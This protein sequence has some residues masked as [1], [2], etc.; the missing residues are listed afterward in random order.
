MA[1]NLTSFQET[2]TIHEEAGAAPRRDEATEVGPRLDPLREV[3]MSIPVQ[4]NQC[5]RR[6]ALKEGYAGKAVKCKG[7]GRVLRVPERPARRP[8][9]AAITPPELDVFGVDDPPAA[10]AS[11]EDEAVPAPRRAPQGTW[12][13]EGRGRAG[14]RGRSSSA[15]SF[16]GVA[17]GVLVVALFA[18]RVY[19]RVIR[20]LQDLPNVAATADEPPGLPPARAPRRAGPIT[21]PAFPELGP[22]VV[23]EPGVR[24]H[25]VRL[26]PNDPTPESPGH[27]GK[28]WLYLPDG[29]HDP[30]ALPCILI[31]G[32]G[33]N[34]ITGMDLGA[35]DRREHLPYVRAGFAV[36]AYELDGARQESDGG[37]ALLRSC[38]AFL[39]AQAGLVNARNALGFLE[40]RV[41]EVD[42]RRVYAVGHSSA[43]TLALLVAENEPRIRGCVAFAPVLDTA[44][45]F[46]EPA[47]AELVRLLPDAVDFFD[48]YNPRQHEGAIA[49]PVFL[50]HAEDDSNVPVSESL[51][52]RDRLASLGKSVTLET[53]P[54][55]DHYEAMVKQGIPLAIAWLKRLA[56]F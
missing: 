6:Y 13:S 8:A 23:L 55:G 22:G 5:G 3:P 4:C 51:G 39:A 41:P 24:F 36:L 27:R 2:A 46:P 30:R 37:E 47:R 40:R 33:S 18:W 54:T 7:C 20:P 25:E 28:L 48:R 35:G 38:Q 44:A 31:A 43:A 42:L 21:P 15:Q 12:T 49:C 52:C 10:S 9:R 14:D 19:T 53:V 34:L 11:P 16:L 17:V 32:A 1:L 29:P 56:G 50:F 26:G 45:R